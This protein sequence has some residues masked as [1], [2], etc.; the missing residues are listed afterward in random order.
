MAIFNDT[1]GTLSKLNTLPLDK[2]KNL[3]KLVEDNL[4]EVL[5][6]HFLAMVITGQ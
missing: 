3:Q 4:M 6:L 5:E 2:E 1:Q